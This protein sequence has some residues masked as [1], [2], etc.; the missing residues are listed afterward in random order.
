M[1]IIIGVVR[2][3]TF[4]PGSNAWRASKMAQEG[5][6]EKYLDWLYSA[7]RMDVRSS[8]FL[9]YSLPQLELARKGHD[10]VLVV[11]VS[12]E[13]PSKYRD[14]LEDA[15]NIYPFLRV[16]QLGDDD[17][18]SNDGMDRIARSIAGKSNPIYAAFRL[19]DDDLL[20]A[21]YC[22]ELARHVTVDCVGYGVSFGRGFTGHY[23][24]GQF[25]DLRVY[26]HRMF[27]AGLATICRASSADGT[28]PEGIHPALGSHSSADSRVPVVSDCR[29]P[30]FLRSF[31]DSNDSELTDLSA[32]NSLE[33]INDRLAGQLPISV[34]DPSLVEDFPSVAAES[35]RRLIYTLTDVGVE[36]GGLL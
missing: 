8:I 6:V 12:K 31:H 20:S 17:S 33:M 13:L 34:D 2:Y 14:Q 10:L 7:D 24:S 29:R 3:S 32:K 19:D 23:D 9:D 1:A 5:G 35:K 22:N 36:G 21:R 27:S 11:R 4:E 26:N 25:R 30:M 15:A 16:S 18:Q 28:T